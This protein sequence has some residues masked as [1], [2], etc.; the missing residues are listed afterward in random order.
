MSLSWADIDGNGSLNIFDI[1]QVIKVIVNADGALGYESFADKLDETLFPGGGYT[2]QQVNIF[3]LLRMIRVIIGAEA[4]PAYVAPPVTGGAQIEISQGSV[5]GKVEIK[6]TGSLTANIN[7]FEIYC[8]PQ[9]SPDPQ[10]YSTPAFPT[11]SVVS[12]IMGGADGWLGAAGPNGVA[13]ASATAVTLIPGT[14]LCVVDAMDVPLFV[15]T[16]SVK[17]T[18][19]RDE[20]RENIILKEDGSNL[21]M[22]A[23]LRGTLTKKNIFMKW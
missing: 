8:A 1:L 16:A 23:G 10:V 18:N 11:D 19:N 9:V 7:G 3:L 17:F 13:G 15:D 5:A 6:Y 12:T 22:A 4:A 21:L 20:D 14:V 2:Q